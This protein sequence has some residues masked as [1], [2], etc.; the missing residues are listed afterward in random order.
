M[1]IAAETP[2]KSRLEDSIIK[3][4]NH[5][6]KARTCHTSH[7]RLYEMHKHSN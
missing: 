5:F 6:D 2:N 3:P 4:I 1:N 7:H